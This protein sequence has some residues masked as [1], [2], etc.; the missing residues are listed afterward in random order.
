MRL[1]LLE[2]AIAFVIAAQFR[3]LDSLEKAEEHKWSLFTFYLLQLVIFIS[4]L[5]WG[6]WASAEDAAELYI[7]NTIGT[8]RH[9]CV[10]EGETYPLRNC[11]KLNCIAKHLRVGVRRRADLA[12]HRQHVPVVPTTATGPS[13]P[14]RDGVD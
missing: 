10:K 3:I 1:F 14:A 7:A 5:F 9:Y 2:L 6:R 13:R 11:P 4:T 12:R 8:S